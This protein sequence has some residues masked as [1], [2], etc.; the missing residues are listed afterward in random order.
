MKSLP[1][2]SNFVATRPGGRNLRI[3]IKWWTTFD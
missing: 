3:S 1:N 2:L